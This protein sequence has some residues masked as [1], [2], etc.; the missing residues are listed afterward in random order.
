MGGRNPDFRQRAV[1]QQQSEAA[2]IAL[3]GL[4]RT[5]DSL[6][7]LERM[8]QMWIEPS[9]FHRPHDPHPAAAGFNRYGAFGRKCFEEPLHLA[10]AMA[11]AHRSA[12]SAPLIHN[13]KHRVIPMY[14]ASDILLRIFH[15]LP[16]LLSAG[17]GYFSPTQGRVPTPLKAAL[18]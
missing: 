2:G 4:T 3:V 12:E 17:W 5:C 16:R 9:L 18:S 7:H 10:I 13:S 1:A 15:K 11:D 14:I 8:G 6:L